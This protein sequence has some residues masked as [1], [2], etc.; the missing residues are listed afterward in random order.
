MI[1]THQGHTKRR[2]FIL[3]G[4]LLLS[5]T[6]AGLSGL[7]IHFHRNY[8][9]TPKN[10]L[11]GNTSTSLAALKEKGLPFSFLVIG[12]TQCNET[13]EVLVEKALQKEN[14]SF[15]VFVGDFV[16][17]PDVWYH[18]FFLSEM[19]VEMKPPFPVFLASG[20]HDIYYPSNKDKR[21]EKKISME[22]RMTPEKYESLYGARS[23]DFVFN[24]CLFIIC[25]VDMTNPAGYLDELRHTLSQKGADTKHIFVFVHY[26]PKG[27]AEYI[28][29]SLPRE[30]QFFSLLEG[31]R[32]VTCFFG[33]FHGYWRGRRN[34]VN[35]IVTGGGGRLRD[36]QQVWGNFNHIIRV[37]VEANTVSE[38]MIAVKLGILQRIMDA[39]DEFGQMVFTKIF[40]VIQS[41]TWVLYGFFC[42]FSLSAVCFFVL[43]AGSL[44]RRLPSRAKEPCEISIQE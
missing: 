2:R 14:P 39:E 25:A 22:R 20:N 28:T 32:D 30:D 8:S 40:P 41:Q 17:E 5:L 31:Y 1:K 15:M 27:L 7:V 12:D 18:R 9:N 34:G 38:E 10:H 36:F 44:V 21:K 33:D 42:L 19:A 29:A 13:V 23:F 24:D 4:F 11:I 26:P 37:T 16:K 6:L 3:L 35:L 43:F